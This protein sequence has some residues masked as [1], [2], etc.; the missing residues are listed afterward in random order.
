MCIASALPEGST[1]FD[2]FRAIAQSWADT[3]L[4]MGLGGIPR[5]YIFSRTPPARH[6]IVPPLKWAAE[7][8]N[9]IY[10]LAIPERNTLTHT[11]EWNAGKLSFLVDSVH[12]SDKD[13]VM[14][15]YE[16]VKSGRAKGKVLIDLQQS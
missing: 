9:L 11:F 15:A 4:P 5:K 7:G 13:G 8:K 1:W 2:F 12:A 6:R 10:A 3:S 14:A 16:R